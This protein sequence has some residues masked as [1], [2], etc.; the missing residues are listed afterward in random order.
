LPPKRLVALTH[1][2]REAF[3]GGDLQE[4]NLLLTQRRIAIRRMIEM[5]Q[6][7]SEEERLAIQKADDLLIAAMR[8][9]KSDLMNRL[10]QIKV[11]RR[12]FDT[13]RANVTRR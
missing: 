6:K 9:R 3:Y 10:R 1:C 13:Y 5:G 12:V 7:L 8:D 2:I 4:A 11:G